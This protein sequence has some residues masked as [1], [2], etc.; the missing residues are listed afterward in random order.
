MQVSRKELEVAWVEAEQ[1]EN[2]MAYHKT[3]EVYF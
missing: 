3:E 2:R 1:V